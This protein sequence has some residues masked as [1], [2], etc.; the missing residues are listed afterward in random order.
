MYLQEIYD[1]THDQFICETINLCNRP[2]NGTDDRKRFNEITGK[3][4]SIGKNIKK[5][6]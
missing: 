1:R 2:I 5:Y 4:K 3:L 6:Y